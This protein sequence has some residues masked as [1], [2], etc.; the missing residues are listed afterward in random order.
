MFV[1]SVS[2]L[3]FNAN[4]LMRFDGYYILA[5]LL[6]IPNLRQKVG[7]GHPAEARRV[8]AR[9]A[10]AARSVPAAAAPLAVCRL[11]R[12]LRG[13]WLARLAVDLLVSVRVLEPYGLKIVGQLL[14]LAMIV[15]ADRAAAGAADAIS[16][17]SRRRAKT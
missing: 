8:A 12:R 13:L 17:S 16:S 2:T 14:G 3:L 7:R 9:P 5:D 4:P 1:C 15:G 11:Q 6:E 10:R